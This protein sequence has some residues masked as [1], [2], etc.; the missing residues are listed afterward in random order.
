MTSKISRVHIDFMLHRKFGSNRIGN[1]RDDV[2]AYTTKMKKRHLS[3]L[4]GGQSPWRAQVNIQ[5]PL[6]KFLSAR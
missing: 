5:K 2:Y 4:T 6:H 1:S 3:P